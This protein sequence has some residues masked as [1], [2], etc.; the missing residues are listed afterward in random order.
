MDRP[1]ELPITEEDWKQTPPA[2]QAVVIALWQQVNVLQAQVEAL[3]AEV[4]Q[5]RE[6]LGQNS[7]N[8]SK[9]PS[10]DGPEMPPRSGRAKTGRKAGGQKGHKGQG[11]RLKAVEEVDRV[12]DIKPVCC[13]ECG[14]LLM[15]DDQRPARHQVTELPR[16][17]P[18]VTEYRLHSLT[19][20][21]CGAKTKAEWPAD[22]PRG[23]F[24]PCVQATVSYLAGRMGTSQR[25]VKETMES[26]FHVE[27]GLGTI[28]ALEQAVSEALAEPVA[29]AQAYVQQQTV[30]NMDETSWRQK[31]KRVW[32]WEAVTALVTVFVIIG[33]RSRKAAQQVIG[34]DFQGVVGSDRCWA[35]NW[36]EVLQRQLCWAH[37]KRDFQAFV[38]R[39]GESKRIGCALLE[40]VQQMFD[41]WHRLR[42][43]SLS[44]TDF[45]I[46]MSPIQRRVG[47]LLRE[48]T[49]LSHAKTRRTCKNILKLEYA[50][51]A[52]VYLPGVEPT[53]NIAERFL[54]RAVL[55]RRRSFGT[56]SE[57]GSRFVERMLT[58]VTTLRQQNRDVLDYLTQACAAAI[59]GDKAPSLLPDP[60]V[61][62]VE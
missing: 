18:E 37:L 36:L 44:R 32:L 14:T 38:D 30:V 35:Y 40:C 62:N 54:R 25:D 34:A 23:S 51:W 49:Q 3:Q 13:G 19:C 31:G 6:R 1:P 7:Q 41:L 16:I 22:M 47:E 27:M 4:A 48:G 39:G 50:L 56:Q 11:R 29:E 60:L 42:G 8:S 46:K 55:W 58:T 45:Q 21:S 26:V 61:L 20:I 28:P 10:S 12:V 57:V 43:G 59:R 33:S 9:P 17:E 52:F 2:V 53:N 15:G 24:G 5:L